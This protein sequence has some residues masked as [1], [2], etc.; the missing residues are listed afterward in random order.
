MGTRESRAGVLSGFS[1]FLAPATLC[2]RATHRKR[3]AAFSTSS[4]FTVRCDSNCRSQSRC[5]VISLPQMRCHAGRVSPHGRSCA[6]TRRSGLNLHSGDVGGRFRTVEQYD[7]PV[8]SRIVLQRRSLYRGPTM[9]L[10]SVT[11][12]RARR[13]RSLPHS[14]GQ[15]RHPAAA[16]QAGR[17]RRCPGSSSPSRAR[18]RGPWP[19]RRCR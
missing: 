19:D 17:S 3:Q 16:H 2:S 7:Q 10:G 18:R 9:S 15:H 13:K 11:Q 12:S 1:D 5:I 6:A 14:L 4:G 8:N